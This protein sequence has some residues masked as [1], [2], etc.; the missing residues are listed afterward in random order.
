MG[1]NIDRCKAS[2]KANEGFHYG[3]QL[4]TSIEKSEYIAFRLNENSDEFDEEGLY[5]GLEEED[6][7]NLISKHLLKNEN[8]AYMISDQNPENILQNHIAKHHSDGVPKATKLV[9]SLYGTQFF[10]VQSE[11]LQSSGDD[12]ALDGC[13]D[14]MWKELNYNSEKLSYYT[15]MA[16]PKE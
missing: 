13:S 7:A 1:S 8:I 5:T 4:R 16:E 15:Y 6:G 14:F 3:L 2:L 11:W 9:Q 12:Y 10:T